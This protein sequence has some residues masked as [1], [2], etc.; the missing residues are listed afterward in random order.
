MFYTYILLSLKDNK[1]Y[2]GY[3]KDLK[4][5]FQEHTNGLVDATKNRRPLKIIYYEAYLSKQD[6]IVREKSLKTGFGRRYIKNRLGNYFRAYS[7]VG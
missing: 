1:L 6:A 5:R 4:R 7:S 2:V 3:C